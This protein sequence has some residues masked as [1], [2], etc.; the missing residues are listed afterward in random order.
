MRMPGVA[1][2]AVR[3][4]GVGVARVGMT[5]MVMPRVRRPVV[6]VVGMAGVGR[7]AGVRVRWPTFV[8]AVIV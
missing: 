8:V 5:G 3:M 2:G 6:V 1:A 7:V 4:A